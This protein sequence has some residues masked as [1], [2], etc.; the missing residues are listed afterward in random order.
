MREVVAWF[1]EWLSAARAGVR[2][3]LTTAL[4]WHPQLDLIL[5]VNQREQFELQPE[6][7][8]VILERSQHLAHYANVDLFIKPTPAPPEDEEEEAADAAAA[9]FEDMYHSN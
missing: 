8:A 6:D 2:L 4:S 7:Q 5:L 9:N 1:Q 3:A